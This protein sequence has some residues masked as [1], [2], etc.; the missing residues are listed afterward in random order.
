MSS[1]WRLVAPVGILS[2]RKD[3][4]RLHEKRLKRTPI[5]GDKQSNELKE[6][7]KATNTLFRL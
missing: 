1:D 4:S 2:P 6:D 3:L 7:S 5:A